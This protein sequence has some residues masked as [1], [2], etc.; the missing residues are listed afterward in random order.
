MNEDIA[1]ELGILANSQGKTLYSLINE[2]GLAALE[3]RRQGFTLEEATRAKKVVERA[4]KSRKILVNQ[5]LWYMASAIALK[6]ARSKWMKATSE[7]AKWQANVFLDSEGD[8]AFLQSVREFVSDFLWDCSEL[9][10]ERRGAD[11]L[12]LKAVFVP[13]MPIEQTETLFKTF[14]VMFN[15]HGYVVTDFAVRHGFLTAQFKRVALRS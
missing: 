8:D 10:M 11:G 1:Q 5:D 9:V 14:E 12:L 7:N 6:E 13:E 2:L 3:A 4:K 15:S